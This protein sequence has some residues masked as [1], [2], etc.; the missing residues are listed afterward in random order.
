[1]IKDAKEVLHMLKQAMEMG[2]NEKD[3]MLQYSIIK[4][5]D[6]INYYDDDFK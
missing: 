5:Q 1:M 2:Q 3:I 6:A 4:L